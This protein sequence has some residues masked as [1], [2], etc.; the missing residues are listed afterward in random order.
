[1][2]S[3]AWL[4]DGGQ[5]RCHATRR[6]QSPNPRRRRRRRQARVHD[7]VETYDRATPWPSSAGV[8]RHSWSHRP[9]V[10]CS[11]SSKQLIYLWPSRLTSHI[12]PILARSLFSPP[13]VLQL[14][15]PRSRDKPSV[16]H[17]IYRLLLCPEAGNWRRRWAVCVCVC[18]CVCWRL[19]GDAY[20][21][22]TFRSCVNAICKLSATCVDGVVDYDRVSS[23]IVD[24]LNYV[25]HGATYM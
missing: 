14:F 15:Y 9:S 1:M 22:A 11:S 13:F 12:F 17:D 10:L 21:P 18:M 25:L 7:P 20:I 2:T 8:A 16:H 24:V 4:W 6:R 5:V 23:A 19:N 3:L